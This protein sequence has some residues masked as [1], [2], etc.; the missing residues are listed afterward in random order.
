MKG[1]TKDEGMTKSEGQ[2]SREDYDPFGR[3]G[4]TVIVRE[5]ADERNDEGRKND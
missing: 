5:E 2:N 3:D 1:M 4:D